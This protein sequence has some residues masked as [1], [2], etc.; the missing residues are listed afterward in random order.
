LRIFEATTLKRRSEPET[1]GVNEKSI[2]NEKCPHVKLK[3]ARLHLLRARA[4]YRPVGLA[5]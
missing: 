1:E 2:R 5:L 3:L 4:S